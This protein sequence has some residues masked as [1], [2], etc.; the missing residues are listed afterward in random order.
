MRWPVSAGVPEVI[1]FMP[2][3]RSAAVLADRRRPLSGTR[4]VRD[5]GL[6]A[7]SAP[8]RQGRRGANER[9]EPAFFPHAVRVLQP[10][11]A[12]SRRRGV[13]VPLTRKRPAQRRFR[14]RPRSH[15][16]ARACPSSSPWLGGSSWKGA[17]QL[18]FAHRR[19]RAHHDGQIASLQRPDR[20]G[21]GS[22]RRLRREV[23]NAGSREGSE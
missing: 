7:R 10:V 12:S 13:M 21:C 5:G 2:A 8:S 1:C 9:A 18:R 22:A 4:P 15:R 23:E 19:R 16:W 20:L 17:S 11:A 14:R 3:Q 6:P